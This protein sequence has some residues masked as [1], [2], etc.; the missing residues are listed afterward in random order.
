MCEDLRRRHRVDGP[1]PVTSTISKSTGFV[2]C[3][4]VDASTPK[5]PR[6]TYMEVLELCSEPTIE[7]T[8]GVGGAPTEESVLRI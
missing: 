6:T 2:L 7:K 4:M 1:V 5:Y 3:P 8:L